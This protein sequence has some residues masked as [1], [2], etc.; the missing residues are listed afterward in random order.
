MERERD[1]GEGVLRKEENTSGTAEP[2]SLSDRDEAVEITLI[3][4]DQSS[5]LP[6]RQT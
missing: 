5:R 6:H 4:D 1:V 2:T 3:Y